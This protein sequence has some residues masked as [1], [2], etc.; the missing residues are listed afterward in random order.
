MQA[1]RTN[2]FQQIKLKATS[3]SF[4]STFGAS[5]MS[6]IRGFGNDK[7]LLNN[8]RTSCPDTFIDLTSECKKKKKLGRNENFPLRRGCRYF[9]KYHK[10]WANPNSSVHPVKYFFN[11]FTQ[12]SDPVIQLVN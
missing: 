5:D 9:S 2:P 6:V 10:T 3:F 8:R 1:S 12:I 4:S 11:Q 7:Q